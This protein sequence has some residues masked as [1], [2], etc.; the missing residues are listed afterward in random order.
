MLKLGAMAM[1]GSPVVAFSAA[2]GALDERSS[3]AAA[4]RAAQGAAGC[5]AVRAGAAMLAA[6]AFKASGAFGRRRYRRVEL[7][8]DL[9]AGTCPT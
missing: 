5:L 4:R 7:P 3:R 1:R 2:G 8:I 6:D 9:A